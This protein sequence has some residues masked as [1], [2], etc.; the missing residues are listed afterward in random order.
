VIDETALVKGLLICGINAPTFV[1]IG[2]E[3]QKAPFSLLGIFIFT[4]F[5]RFGIQQ[6][7]YN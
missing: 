6:F 7:A 1:V 5:C 4:H 2:K 3:E